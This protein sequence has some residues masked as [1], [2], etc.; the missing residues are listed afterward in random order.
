MKKSRSYNYNEISEPYIC[1]FTTSQVAGNVDFHMHNSHE[2]Y[3]LLDGQIQYYVEN[4]R[5]DM[6][7]GNLILFS[8]REIHKAINLKNQAFTRLVIH[9]EPYF[10]KP[11]STPATNL[12]DCFNREP[13]KNNLVQLSSQ[14]C[15]Q[16]IAMAR[17]LQ[18]TKKNH[19]LYGNDLTAVTTLI[20][21][22]ILINRAW[23]KTGFLKF[24]PKPHRTQ[25][26]MNYID[27]HLTE[28][29]TLSSIAEALSLDKYYISHLFKSETQST[30]FQYIVVKR[31]AFAKELLTEGHTVAEACHLSGFYDY[32]NFIRTF[33]QTTGYTPGQFK[34]LNHS[35]LS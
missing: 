15:D 22:L 9:V 10:I 23:Q 30:I 14:E 25:T 24:T 13:A 28:S 26:I 20:Q 19:C 8:N 7:P 32:S 1:D 5:Y 3:L 33:R 21:I 6:K 11:Y 17:I 18:D 27:A 16:L 12:L 35:L 29:M 31:V 34:R 2:I 4:S